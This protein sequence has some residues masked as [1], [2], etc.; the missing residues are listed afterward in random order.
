MTE[1]GDG[2]YLKHGEFRITSGGKLHGS[3]LAANSLSQGNNYTDTCRGD[4]GGPLS[5]EVVEAE[6][7]D[8][9]NCGRQLRVV[10][11]WHFTLRGCG[12]KTRGALLVHSW[13]TR[14]ALMVPSWCH[15]GA[16]VVP[17][18]CTRGAL[19]V[20][21]WCTRGALVVP[22]WCN[23]GAIVVHSWCIEIIGMK[24]V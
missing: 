8:R 24:V 23:R 13:C 14:G 10:F 4:S 1:D 20:L 9:Y 18:W 2:E 17:S 16:L 11:F 19:V 7:E 12:I 22:S 6:F 3:Q 21:S 15:R 5:F